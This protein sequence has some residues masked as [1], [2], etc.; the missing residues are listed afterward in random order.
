MHNNVYLN[1]IERNV[2]FNYFVVIVPVR[3]VLNAKALNLFL[4]ILVFGF[5]QLSEKQTNKKKTPFKIIKNKQINSIHYPASVVR[6]GME[7][8]HSVL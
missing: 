3:I 7:Y 1:D 2:A 5:D 4:Y 6:V 8:Q